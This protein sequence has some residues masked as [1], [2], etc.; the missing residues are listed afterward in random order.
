M[1]LNGF[2]NFGLKVK[3][4][5]GHREENLVYSIFRQSLV[6]SD[7]SYAMTS[8]LSLGIIGDIKSKVSLSL[9]LKRG[10]TSL[11]YHDILLV[12]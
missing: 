5:G 4:A 9:R 11:L 3:V 10:V 12:D 8:R 1:T 7:F 6:P 2:Q